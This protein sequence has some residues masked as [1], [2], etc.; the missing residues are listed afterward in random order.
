[1]GSQGEPWLDAHGLRLQVDA[2]IEV[3]K[4]LALEDPH[5][6]LDADIL[7]RIHPIIAV[8]D[9]R[10]GKWVFLDTLLTH[11]LWERP[12]NEPTAIVTLS[13]LHSLSASLRRIEEDEPR[14]NIFDSTTEGASRWSSPVQHLDYPPDESENRPGDDGDREYRTGFASQHRRA[15]AN[16]PRP[17]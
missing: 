5:G 15:A 17:W 7:R 4:T 1:M 16:R 12:G 6:K 14:R 13:S 9:E 2:Q 3:V 8:S 11:M 10:Y